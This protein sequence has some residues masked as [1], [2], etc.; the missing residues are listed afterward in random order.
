[1]LTFEY[2]ARDPSTGKEVKADI[3]ADSERSAAKLLTDQ[4]LAPVSIVLKNT[5]SDGIFGFGNRIRT[6]DKVLFSR[7][8]STLINAGL[9]L[10]QSL[11]TVTEQTTNK[12]MVVVISQIISDIEGGSSFADSLRA[13]PDVF[14]NVYVNLVAAGESSGTL[15]EALERIANQQEK[16]AEIVSKV[17]GA[18]VYPVIV[19]VV[20]AGV[21]VFML[22]TVL[23]QV[24]QLYDDLKQELPIF[25]KILLAISNFLVNYWWVILIS[26]GVIF[27]LSRRYFRTP[28]GQEVIDKF[29][30]KAPVIGPLF[31]KMYMARF[32]RTGQ[33]LMASGVPMLEMMHITGKAVNNVHIERSLERA[34]EKVKGGTALSDSLKN[35]ENFLPL[36]P[37]MI[38]I[39]EQSGAI[40]AMMG[41]AASFYE[42]EL[43]N[44]IKTISTTIEPVLMVV[45]AAVAALMVA[46]I[47]LPVYG[48][49]GQNLAL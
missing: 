36:V 12:N 43:D 20:I 26:L 38:N 46:A 14:N 4:G 15:D 40:D 41:K 2:K 44:Q 25:T 42:N 27:V 22:T 47:L 21:I 9:P 6:K 7:Q 32:S 37:Q 33:T 30:M 16:D 49:V 23:P 5:K 24:E 19:L 3:E 39:G 31:M 45:L 29:K 10:T 28:A 8:L 35:N 17:R 13:H 11:R 48:L 18:M 1:M 34:A